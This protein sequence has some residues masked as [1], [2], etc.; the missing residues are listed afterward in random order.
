MDAHNFSKTY[1]NERQITL[2]DNVYNYNFLECAKIT[3]M[4]ETA[5]S[6]FTECAKITIMG[7]SQD[8]KFIACEEITIMGKAKDCEFMNCGKVTIMGKAEDCKFQGMTAE[9]IKVSG[10]MDDCTLN[11]KPFNI[12]RAS[13][14]PNIVSYG[15]NN[16]V[17]GGRVRVYGG[18]ME[19]IISGGQSRTIIG[20]MRTN[21][22]GEEIVWNNV[23]VHGIAGTENQYLVV[24]GT[25]TADG[26]PVTTGKYTKKNG[27]VIKVENNQNYTYNG[28]AW[29]PMESKIACTMCN[30]PVSTKQGLQ[31]SL[32]DKVQYC[33]NKC[34][35]KHWPK[36]TLMH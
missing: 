28:Q 16:V 11:G 24:S 12:A 22:N 9:S 1:E 13:K 6:Q 29:V 15:N 17:R 26:V 2:S 3:I 19:T 20:G 33:S 5:D 7:K 8:S 36:H 14:S 30:A 4:G 35:D 25:G 10:A 18:S 34:A 23:D 32:C 27:K 31:C 21:Y